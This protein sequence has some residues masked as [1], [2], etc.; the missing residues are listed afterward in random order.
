MPVAQRQIW[1]D[2]ASGLETIAT[3]LRKL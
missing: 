1:Q 2:I 3:A